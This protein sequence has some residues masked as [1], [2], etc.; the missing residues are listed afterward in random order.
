M[1][2]FTESYFPTQN[3]PEYTGERKR[4]RAA[5]STHREN[6]VPIFHPLI[7]SLFASTFHL[8]KGGGRGRHIH[9]SHT[10][11]SH[12]TNN[13]K[14]N[15]QIFPQ[16]Y[17]RNRWNR[18]KS[19]NHQQVREEFTAQHTPGPGQ[20]GLTCAG[21]GHTELRVYGSRWRHSLAVSRWL[22]DWLGAK[23]SLLRDPD[24]TQRH[25]LSK[26]AGTS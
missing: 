5:N 4:W 26:N 15:L 16:N 2:I 6:R 3:V 8:P 19:S 17:E 9:S 7:I 22:T 18:S 1:T 21:S 14:K 13:K 12:W 23:L 11:D 20:T 10:H 24:I 25:A